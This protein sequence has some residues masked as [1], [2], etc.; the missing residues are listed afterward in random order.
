MALQNFSSNLICVAQLRGFDTFDGNV[1]N[2]LPTNHPQ[3]HQKLAKGVLTQLL[4][5]YSGL[6]LGFTTLKP[7]QLVPG[8]PPP[9]LPI[10][11]PRVGNCLRGCLAPKGRQAVVGEEQKKGPWNIVILCEWYLQCLVGFQV[12]YITIIWGESIWW[13]SKMR[14][15]VCIWGQRCSANSSMSMRGFGVSLWMFG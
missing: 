5:V 6:S 9:P 2:P 1:A 4:M 11:K 14:F 7:Q 13:S 8:G 10:L 3:Y 15:S 12:E